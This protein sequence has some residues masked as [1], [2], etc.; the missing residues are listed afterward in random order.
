MPS[1]SKDDLESSNPV[2]II[3]SQKGM[4]VEYLFRF[5]R[6]R[7]RNRR[8]VERT[9]SA[10]SQRGI[11]EAP[12]GKKSPTPRFSGRNR[13]QKM[14]AITYDYDAA[15]SQPDVPNFLDLKKNGRYPM[16][17]GASLGKRRKQER[18]ESRFTSRE[19]FQ[20]RYQA[21]G[22]K[23]AKSNGRSRSSASRSAD[24][25]TESVASGT[26]DDDKDEKENVTVNGVVDVE[27]FTDFLKKTTDAQ[28]LSYK[29]TTIE[30]I[31]KGNDDQEDKAEDERSEEND[32]PGDSEHS[33]KSPIPQ[34]KGSRIPRAKIVALPIQTVP[35]LHPSGLGRRE[36]FRDGSSRSL[37]ELVDRRISGYHGWNRRSQ[38]SIDSAESEI[39]LSLQDLHE[40]G[41]TIHESTGRR[42]RFEEFVAGRMQGKEMATETPRVHRHELGRN[43][44][45]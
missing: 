26:S 40:S 45:R 12:S 33:V 2:S 22:T 14:S 1:E 24:R 5:Q 8:H 10:R 42:Q 44:V 18:V 6:F 30:V 34:A 4:D 3:N 31:G 20:K 13:E 15:V 38:S 41:S 17:S 39:E 32:K 7:S 21:P 23:R 36:E 37:T 16:V 9:M 19:N 27:N 28:N 11:H 25:A 29:I 43:V 35:E